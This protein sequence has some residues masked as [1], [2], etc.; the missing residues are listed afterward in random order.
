MH[1][2]HYYVYC[3]RH[4]VTNEIRYIGKTI[5][6]VQTKNRHFQI[7]EQYNLSLQIVAECYG[8]NLASFIESHLIL[9][10]SKTTVLMNKKIG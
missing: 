6:L 9:E 1:L 2:T 3:L 10:L 5:D 4:N 8:D 7:A